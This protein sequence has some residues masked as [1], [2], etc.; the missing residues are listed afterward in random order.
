MK[1]DIA[2]RFKS[3]LH[4]KD[5]SYKEAST[6]LDGLS[7][8]QINDMANGIKKITPEIALLIE[9]KLNINPI[10]LIFGRGEMIEA[11]MDI[12]ENCKEFMNDENFDAKKYLSKQNEMID[13]MRKQNEEL[14]KKLK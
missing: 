12:G 2:K 14:A 9:E 13:E 4:I 11:K 8:Q 3:V 5:Y 6:L 10:W 7:S 1:N